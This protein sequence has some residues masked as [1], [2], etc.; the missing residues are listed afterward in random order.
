M[1]DSPV[2]SEQVPGRSGEG[3]VD[4]Q[5]LSDLKALVQE[6]RSDMSSFLAQ[7]SAQ[8]QDVRYA[9]W[10]GQ[11]LKGRKNAADIGGRA[12]PFE[13]ASDSRVR[14]ADKIIN[15]RVME[16]TIAAMRAIPKAVGIE[17]TDSGSEGKVESLVRWLVKNQWGPDYFRQCELAAQFQEGDNPALA[18]LMVD[19]FEE[20]S[21]EYRTLT[22]EEFAATLAQQEAEATGA[23]VDLAIFMDL[24][25]NPLRVS[26]L[27][28]A[29]LAIIPD[30][31]TAHA[32]KM[33]K[34]LNAQQVTRY[35]AV[36]T[37]CAH[38]KMMA[39]RAYIDLFYPANT[40]DPQ[41]CRVYFLRE[42]MC[43]AEV[44]Q[45]AALENWP[46]AFVTE[47]IGT[48]RTSERG[49]EGRSAFDDE[50]RNEVQGNG[51]M[52][53]QD[54]RGEY[55]VITAF[56]RC[57]NEDGV[58]AIYIR[59]FS[60]F[61]ETP[62]TGRVLFDR[63]HGKYPFVFVPRES[64]TQRVND[65]RSVSEL[66]STNQNSLKLLTD[67]FE[68]HVQVT[69]NPPV[70]VPPGRPFS[71]I[72]LSPFGKVE[73]TARDNVEFMQ[74]PAYPQAADKFWGEVR[75]EINEYFGRP[76]EG[77]PE[78]LP[79]LHSQF[80]VDRFLSCLSEAL[81]MAVQLMQQFMTDEQIQ[82]IVGGNGMPIART[83]EE[84]QGR[85]DISL[86]FDVRD[87][88]MEYLKMKAELALKYARPLDVRNTTQWHKVSNRIL[89]SIDPNWAEE[90]ILPAEMADEREI[91]DEEAAFVSCLNGVEPPMPADGINAPL[92]LQ[93]FQGLVDARASNPAAYPPVSPIS[94]AMLQNRLK[95]LT[96]QKDQLENADIGRVGAEPVVPAEVGSGAE[97]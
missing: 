52:G 48:E 2:N 55:E 89:Q 14:V 37:K 95:Y 81:M 11:N 54:H 84:I 80:R 82:R 58:M 41:R 63:K 92:R 36:Y 28:Q 32:G 24:A 19:W 7:Q 46:D 10:S 85:Y 87:L 51:W 64:L 60:A 15:E 96:F 42:W 21:I 88:N 97:G 26:E 76:G 57:V 77:I 43:R 65:S 8:L 50:L 94:Q 93:V 49:H 78:M 56:Q 29:L 6:I 45:S 12:E 70:K 61:C 40:H 4:A 35:P 62:A 1:A 71:T 9:R 66:A 68:D 75:R 39:L 3:P 23:P 22:A 86:S 31:P 91:R 73:A 33:A 44:L 79:Q 74:R 16:K 83:V 25:T 72:T 59:K 20:Q 17:G 38:A 67:S 90:S 53:G 27:A 69:I 30:L 5:E 18:V 34:E 13:N 47:L